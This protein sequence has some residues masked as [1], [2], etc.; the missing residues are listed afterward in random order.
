[1][2]EESDYVTPSRP[3]RFGAGAFSI[4]VII[5]LVFLMLAVFYFVKWV[6][7][8]EEKIDF[9]PGGGG[10]GGNEGQTVSKIKA[11]Q[12]MMTSPAL[13]KRIAVAG[14][15]SFSLPDASPDFASAS[16]PMAMSDASSGSGGGAGGGRGTGIGKGFGSGSGMGS[17]P[18]VGQGFVSTSVFGGKQDRSDA[19]AGHL[20][21]FKQ[22]EKGKAVEYDI[23]NAQ[24][25]ITRAHDLQNRR[26]RD[27][28]FRKFF[29]APDT[30]YLTQLAIPLRPA[31]EGPALFGAG[32]KMKPS[33]WLAH[34]R[35]KIKAP[36]TMSFR[37]VGSADD[38][39]AVQAK[40]RLRLV[41]ARPELQAPVQD[42]WEPAAGSDAYPGPMGTLVFGDWIQV[43]AGE[44]LEMDLAIGERPGG[45]VGFLLLVEEKDKEYRTAG[46]GRPILPIF[47]TEAIVDPI[48]ERITKGF[49]DWEFEWDNVP[50][51][52][53]RSGPDPLADPFR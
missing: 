8:P 30:L 42:K 12:R 19:L 6:E 38:Y 9:L 48:R 11:Q 47:T 28:A 14:P 35:G 23:G 31:D 4:S 21:D 32:D 44:E 13:S 37:F 18:G 1:M 25:F 34:Y 39:I 22:D 45:V 24:H 43:R 20:Y 51:F 3:R 17:G 33:G 50:V 5:H 7:P 10:G 40:G 41:A 46:N 29:K 49:P 26:F 53:N 15:A 27:S 36:R 52:T 2:T 16:M